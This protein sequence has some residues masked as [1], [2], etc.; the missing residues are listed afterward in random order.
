MRLPPLR[1]HCIA[2][3]RMQ[4]ILQT[5][6]KELAVKYKYMCVTYFLFQSIHYKHLPGKQFFH[7][8]SILQKRK[9]YI[10][11]MSQPNTISWAIETSRPL[12]SGHLGHIEC[13][14]VNYSV[15]PPPRFVV[16]NC[17]QRRPIL[18]ICLRVCGDLFL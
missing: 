1:A 15:L 11:Y 14:V 5:F 8:V 16:G 17:N 10:L 9:Y 18:D 6:L 2:A 13:A 12:S 7:I 3:E 4:S